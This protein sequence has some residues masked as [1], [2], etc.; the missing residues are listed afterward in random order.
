MN[1][2]TRELA[3]LALLNHFHRAYSALVNA[4]IEADKGLNS[5]NLLEKLAVTSNPNT[6]TYAKG[7]E[8]RIFGKSVRYSTLAEALSNPRETTVSIDYRVTFV[9]KRGIWY[10]LE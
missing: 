2:E 9:R 3:A 10:Y 4:F 8:P 6:I 1:N 7:R 5:Q